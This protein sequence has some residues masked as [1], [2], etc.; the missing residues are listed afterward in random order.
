MLEELVKA[1]CSNEATATRKEYLHI[2]GWARGEVSFEL[3]VRS[4]RSVRWCC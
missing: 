4:M 1:V 2:V 3:I